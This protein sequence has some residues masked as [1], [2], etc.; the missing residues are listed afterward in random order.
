MHNEMDTLETKGARQLKKGA[1]YGG[2]L[3]RY[4]SV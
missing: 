3:Y 4:E 1:L 2:V